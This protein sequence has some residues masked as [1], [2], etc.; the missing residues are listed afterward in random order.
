MTGVS[1]ITTRSIRLIRTL[2]EIIV[3]AAG[4]LLG[5]SVGIGTV[6][7]ALT[8]GAITQF[9]LPRFAYR[10]NDAQRGQTARAGVTQRDARQY[11][12]VLRR[13]PRPELGR[14]AQGSPGDE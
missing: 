12:T 2:I 11:R 1:G 4:W 8:V 3:L 5:G 13:P 9:L 7:Y 14:H 10:G 6:L